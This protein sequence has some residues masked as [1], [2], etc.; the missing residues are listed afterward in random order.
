M[1]KIVSFIN[2]K[3]AVGKTTTAVN[4]AATLANQQ[5]SVL[6]SRDRRRSFRRHLGWGC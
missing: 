5:N 6:A 3:G 2:L 4:I 1:A